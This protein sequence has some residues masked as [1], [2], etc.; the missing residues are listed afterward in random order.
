[1]DALDHLS[2]VEREVIERVYID[3]ETID[4]V[5]DAMDRPRARVECTF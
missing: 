3:G 1:V 5:C 2:I 4:E